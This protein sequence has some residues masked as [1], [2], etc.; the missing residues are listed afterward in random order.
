MKVNS[1]E[2]GSEKVKEGN[3]ETKSPK[4]TNIP[5]SET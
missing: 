4:N 3:G 2:K 5:Q 1:A